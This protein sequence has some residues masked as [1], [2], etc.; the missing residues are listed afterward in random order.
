MPEGADPC[1]GAWDWQPCRCRL[2]HNLALAISGGTP[3]ESHGPLPI[4]FSYVGAAKWF[5][6]YILSLTMK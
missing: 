2:A 5:A 1:S 6:D 4:P 3:H